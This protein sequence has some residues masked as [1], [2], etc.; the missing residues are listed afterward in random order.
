MKKRLAK[1]SKPRIRGAVPRSR[2]FDLLDEHRARPAVWIAGPPG[3]GKTVLL[4]TYLE[5]RKLPT[6]WFEV[7]SGES[8]PAAFFYYLGLALESEGDQKQD[9]LPLLTPE[10]LSDLPGFA[11]RFFRT[12][13]ERM[14]APAALVLDNYQEVFAN[15]I[16]HTLIERMLAEI[17]EGINVF[18]LSRTGPPEECSRLLVSGAIAQIG[19]DELRLTLEETAEIAGRCLASDAQRLGA[20][21][22]QA[23][24]WA[25]GTVLMA[26]RLQHTGALNVISHPGG[27]DTVFGYFAGQVF[28]DLPQIA[29][30]VLM[31]TAFLSH[32]SAPVAARISN[33]PHAGSV[34]EDMF[35]RH[36][37]T[38]RRGGDEPVYHYHALFSAF[39]REEAR[40][41][42]PADELKRLIGDTAD[43][44]AADGAIEQA[45]A[46]YLQVE[47]WDKARAA[48]L[49]SASSLVAQGRRETVKDWIL[50]LPVSILLGESWL[51]FWLGMCYAA[52]VPTRARG[53]FEDAYESFVARGDALGQMAAAAAIIETHMLEYEFASLKKWV[54]AL[55]A[56]LQGEP[57]FPSSEMALRVYCA[58]LLGTFYEQP[59][60]PLLALSVRQIDRL[61][62]ENIEVNRKV[63]AGAALLPYCA[64]KGDI[65]LAARTIGRIEPL[66]HDPAVLPLSRHWWRVRQ[67]TFY[68]WSMQYDKME[69]GLEEA[70]QIAAAHNWRSGAGFECML[71]GFLAAFRHDAE[72]G[73]VT[74]QRFEMLRSPGK[75]GDD[76]FGNMIHASCAV[77]TGDHVQALAAQDAAMAG[78][79]RM[80]FPSKYVAVSNHVQMLL[81]AGDLA[82]ARSSLEYVQGM[83]RGIGLDCCEMEVRFLEAGVAW[84]GGELERCNA[85]LEDCLTF[86]RRHNFFGYT[87]RWMP[88]MVGHLLSQALQ[89]GI[90]TDYV[91]SVIRS[92][93]LPP[94]ALEVEAW[95]WPVKIYTLGHFRVVIDG[96]PLTFN[97]KAQKKPLEL[98]KA[99]V[100]LGGRDVDFPMLVELLWPDAE[101]AR[102]SG[103]M[104]L[105]RLRKLLGR[106]DT[107]LIA[108]GKLALNPALVWLD[109]DAFESLLRPAVA[110]DAA[111]L[112]QP[113]FQREMR[114]TAALALYKGHF[115]CHEPQ[116]PWAQPMTDRLRAK[117]LR[118][119]LDA[120]RGWEAL[121]WDQAALIY[122]RGLELDNLAEEFYQRLMVCHRERG[123]MADAIRVYRRCREN[124]SIILGIAPSPETTALYNSLHQ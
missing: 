110:S 100:A 109:A 38:D 1:L 40:L 62:A 18:I 118:Q 28:K 22:A 9:G 36:M 10:Y 66:I 108:D 47:S 107:V 37:F 90:A 31:R 16:F 21:H 3:A 7:D 24:G 70:R 61:L 83:V 73:R 82:R 95:P 103:E 111:A 71:S 79:E 67:S 6:V 19:F 53:I 101:D 64:W 80:W 91:C 78:I 88:E 68:I 46:L 57:R 26:E 76:L 4:S 11:R 32:M 89:A 94:P 56:L 43:L 112:A 116:T 106:A 102:K 99:L 124:L 49:Q 60:H 30:S 65:E 20:L 69:S 48:I 120:G 75:P 104:T 45:I 12:F 35:K 123:S 13:F 41:A 15:S 34:L 81:Q 52:T 87:F 93:Q 27:M 92:S 113:D 98:L 25:A 63:M 117:Y 14:P 85:A 17:P 42:L 115:L 105:S 84:A 58:C 122:E 77:A 97:G 74:A 86:F 121:C 55:E 23:D 59:G 51:K 96:E 39:L 54:S 5:A 29:R 72:A 50:A 2:L 33:E 119:V 114:S 44:L 8:D